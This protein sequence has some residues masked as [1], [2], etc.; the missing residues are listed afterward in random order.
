MTSPTRLLSS[1]MAMALTV[2]RRFLPDIASFFYHYISL[3]IFHRLLPIAASSHIRLVLLNR[4]GYAGSTPFSPEDVA[5]FAESLESDTGTEP[6]LS[7]SPRVIAELYT[8]FLQQRGAEIARFL[9]KFIE[10]EKIS[11]TLAAEGGRAI[12]GISLMGYSLGNILSM[13]MLALAN[14]YDPAL[15]KQLEPY[16]RKVVIY[17]TSNSFYYKI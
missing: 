16:L 14:T 15:I 5:P 10:I 2:V 4:R 9:Q 6:T 11:P 7:R 17:G 13:S 12:G 8:S 3:D 1:Y